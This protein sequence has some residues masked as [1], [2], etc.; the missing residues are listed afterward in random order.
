MGVGAHLGVEGGSGRGH[1][2]LGAGPA[3]G[4]A[5]LQWTDAGGR[6]GGGGGRS[7]LTG[8]LS[9][10]LTCRVGGLAHLRGH[11]H[12]P[13]TQG[14]HQRIHETVMYPHGLLES[15]GVSDREMALEMNHLAF[16]GH[17][18]AM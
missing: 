10:H 5:G 9:Q 12:G 2:R 6:R 3:A 1:P 7:V 16:K 4:R 18:N 17:N 14:E 15:S 13:A 8:H 11:A